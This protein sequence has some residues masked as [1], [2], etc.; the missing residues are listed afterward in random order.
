V[1]IPA[2][3]G[4][5]GIPKKNIRDLNGKPMIAYTIEAALASPHVTTVVVSTDSEEIAQVAREYGAEVPFLRPSE[6][7]QDTSKTIDAVM[8]AVET[9]AAAG[10]SFDQLI[11][12]QPTSPLR[13][14]SDIDLCMQTFYAHDEQPLV[15]VS[16][17]HDHPILIRSLDETGYVHHLLDVQST[18]R[19]QDM[20]RYYRVDGSVFVARIKDLSRETSINDAPIGCVLPKENTIDIDSLDDF[21]YAEARLKA[22]M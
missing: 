1:L 14:T 10:R 17:V 22:Q 12:L 16:E 7:A 21:Y 18:V 13:T 19:R 11:L 20:P 2:R 3:G 15:S 8:H 4:S 9:L 5:K 6:L